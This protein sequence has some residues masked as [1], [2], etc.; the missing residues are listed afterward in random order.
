M[1]YKTKDDVIIGLLGSLTRSMG[2]MGCPVM[3]PD[4]HTFLYKYMELVEDDS[5]PNNKRKD[6]IQKVLISSLLD[7]NKDIRTRLEQLEKNS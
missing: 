3:I 5:I 7:E 2:Y 4:L 6:K 1:E